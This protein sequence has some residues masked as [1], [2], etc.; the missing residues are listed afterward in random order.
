LHTHTYRHT[1]IYTC[2]YCMPDSCTVIFKW[3]IKSTVWIFW[4]R[5]VKI[6]VKNKKIC[7]YNSFIN[8]S[9]FSYCP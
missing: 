6:L 4:F 3:E 5:F 7:N 1:C 2:S 8:V 9:K